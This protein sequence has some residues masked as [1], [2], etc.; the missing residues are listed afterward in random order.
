MLDTLAGYY[1][2]QNTPK[3]RSI[4]KNT[5]V[6]KRHL[7]APFLELWNNTDP[8]WRHSVYLKTAREI[9][10]KAILEQF[11]EAEV[12]KDDIDMIIVTSCTGFAFPSLCAY[13]INDLD[14][15]ESTKQ[16]PMAQL[17]C[18]A[19]TVGIQK[20]HD[21]LKAYPGSNVL[22]VNLE[23]C[24]MLYQNKE[25]DLGSLICDGLFGDC[26]TA[27][28]MRG[29]PAPSKSKMSLKLQDYQFCKLLKGSIDL[30]YYD[31]SS[32]GW[33]FRLDKRLGQAIT[34]CG[35]AMLKFGEERG[36]DYNK[37]DSYVMHTG[38]PK[39]LSELADTL[40]I[41]ESPIRAKSC[42]ECLA[43]SGN[44]ASC[45]IM[46]ILAREFVKRKVGERA[47]IGSFGPGFTA[48]LSFGEFVIA[49]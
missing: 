33:T 36:I 37:F 4:L 27:T 23:L 1:P 35:P 46:D 19:G 31:V 8:T 16:L 22:I 48:A 41:T 40:S 38:G 5:L 7:S 15:A 47:V 6:Q 11:A 29:T 43:N 13:F 20:A 30:L 9:G 21:H 26:C 10:K 12:T 14:M 49:E 18:A 25:T 44:T 39:V 17:G 24:S 34:N 45:M 2:E 28:V 32:T 3:L 42:L